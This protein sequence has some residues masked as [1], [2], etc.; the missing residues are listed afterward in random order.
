[1]F[2]PVVNARPK[3][4][5]RS[6]RTFKRVYDYCYFEETD[7]RL[8]NGDLFV[9]DYNEVYDPRGIYEYYPFY[10]PNFWIKSLKH[11]LGDYKK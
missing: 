9:V 8:I 6:Y 11:E 10:S 1:M 7:I 5:N 4:V 3:N 2:I